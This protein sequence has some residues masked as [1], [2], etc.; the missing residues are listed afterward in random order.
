MINVLGFIRN[1]SWK[2]LCPSAYYR[3]YLPL[4]ECDRSAPDINAQIV[5]IDALEGGTDAG[6]MGR[7]IY[8]LSR[9]YADEG[10]QELVDHIHEMGGVSVFDTDDDLTEDHRYISGRG[11]AFK[12]MLGVVDYVSVSTP[13]LA[14]RLGQ[15]TKQP[16]TALRNQLDIDWF[17]QTA[18]TAKRFIPGLTVGFSGTW[19]HGYD[20]Q[21][22]GAAFE[23][24]IKAGLDFQGLVHGL[25]PWY[26]HKVRDSIIKMDKVPY[27]IYP[28]LL[29][30]FDILLCAVDGDD[31][32]NVGKSAIKPIEAM[33][34]GAVP[35][36]SKN[37]QAYR[38]LH[39]AGAPIVMVGNQEACW[40]VAI[41]EL[42]LDEAQRLELSARGPGWVRQN[43]NARTEG[44]KPWAGF[45]RR[46]VK[47]GP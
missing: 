30:Q 26:F 47:D 31:M 18:S 42:V 43:R 33:A 6:L 35:V 5:G 34:V 37:V 25:F 20:W 3:C 36:C 9:M 2:D 27:L 11:E 24:A 29:A 4:R 22:A 19:T 1:H 45:F 40:E 38:D 46:V 15:Y 13:E 32:F 41:R 23:H 44:W 16:P 8:V 21:I 10:H 12:E 7:D 39:A 14:E 17:T 28:T